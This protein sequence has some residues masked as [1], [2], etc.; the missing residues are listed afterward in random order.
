MRQAGITI[1]RF[2][3]AVFLAVFSGTAAFAARPWTPE[4]IAAE[5]AR[6]GAAFQLPFEL[7]RGRTGSVLDE[8]AYFN[9]Y[10]MLCDFLVRLQFTGAGENR[11]GMIEGESGGD[12]GIIETDNTQEAIRVWSQYAIWT[13]DTARYSVNIR[14]AQ[15]YCQRFP[16]WREGAGYYS[17]HNCG[18]GFEAERI[19]R[20]AYSDTSWTWYADSCAWWTVANPL[21]Y[22]PYGQVLGELNPCAQGLGIGGLYPHAVHR[23]RADWR[24][25]AVNQGRMLRTWFESNPARLHANEVWAL[26]GGTALWGLCES[27]F[28]QYP[29]SGRT[30]VNQFGPQL[31]VWQSTGQWNHA[32]NTWYCNAQHKCFEL[33]GDS[34]YWSNAVFITDSLIGLDTDSDGGIPPGR[35]YPVTNDH[36]WVSA[37]MGWMGMERI[38]DALPVSDVAATGFR[39]PNPALPYLA[40]DSLQVTARVLNR[41]MNPTAAWVSARGEDFA[42]S[43]QVQLAAGRDSLIT[44]ARRWVVADRPDLPPRSTLRLAVRATPDNNPVNDTLSMGFDIR[45]GAHVTG[46]ITPALPGDTAVVRIEFY[47]SAY[48][49]S[50]WTAVEQSSAIPFT[51]GPRRLLAGGN[52]IRVVPPLRY[53]ITDSTLELAAGGPTSVNLALPATAIALIDDDAGELY[54]QFYETTLAGFPQNV[55]RW[56]RAAGLPELAPI[57]TVIWFTGRDS[58][59][60]LEPADQT[61]LQAFLDGGGRLLL[62]GQNITDALG[63]GSWFLNDVLRCDALNDNSGQRRIYGE[64]AHPITGGF[65]LYLIG[66]QGAANQY[67][68]ASITVLDG[69]EQILHYAAGSMEA[70]GVSGT[71]GAGRFVFLSFGLEAVS[72]INNTTSREEFLT[73]CFGFFGDSLLTTS[74]QRPAPSL[75]LELAQNFPNPFNPVTTIRFFVPAGAERV[76]LT[77]YNTLGQ[78]LRTLFSGA[79]AGI[80]AVVTW[81]GRSADGTPAASGLYL[82]RLQAGSAQMSRTLQ[83]VR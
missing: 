59:A 32:F 20:H 83:L 55:R 36:S 16:A 39:A 34:L 3:L 81:D 75:A 71:Y 11:G 33:T 10:V 67:S 45:R 23:N 27:L 8:P 12:A 50:L 52:T 38:I 41:G 5:F 66:S 76:T 22:D 48:P 62:S 82:Y 61:L 80:P 51:N 7:P 57:G 2:V 9:H 4:E 79:A 29:D 68:P 43:V 19:Y 13:G 28:A 73:R 49:D 6:S 77:I 15:G 18:W 64:D 21:P 35:S 58:V 60:L 56:S 46:T 42:D 17:I 24:S 14:L 30:W 37:Y 25:F 65:E 54:E 31:D 44:F 1:L 53:M 70:C 78:E 69:G 40:G 72:G 47:H 74:P 63:A 26:C